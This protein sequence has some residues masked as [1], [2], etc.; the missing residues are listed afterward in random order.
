LCGK[1]IFQSWDIPRRHALL[2]DLSGVL[3]RSALIPMGAF[4]VCEHF[5]GLSST[6]HAV[7]MSEGIESPLDLVFYDLTERLIRRV[8]EESEKISLLLEQEPRSAAEQYNK[9]FNKH[10]GRYLLGTHLMGALAFA[11]ARGYSQLQAAKLLAETVRLLETQKLFPEEIR[12]R[13]PESPALRQMAES[14]REQRRFATAE[15]HALIEKL[16]SIKSKQERRS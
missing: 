14:P 15:L 7:L 11:D 16:K 10:L 13:L 6:D 9:L 3:A 12:T 2:A 8:H 1:D 5:S 4:T